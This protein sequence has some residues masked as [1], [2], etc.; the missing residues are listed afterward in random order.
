MFTNGKRVIRSVFLAL[1]RSK[2]FTLF[3]SISLAFLFLLLHIFS[4]GGIL[5]NNF[6]ENIEKRAD[7]AVFIE[8][9]VSKLRLDTFRNEL[10]GK[11][12]K[13]DIQDFWELPKEEALK[14]FEKNFPEETLFL[15][16]HNLPNP[17]STVFGI[18]PKTSTDAANLEKWILSSD[19]KGAVDQERFKKHIDARERVKRFIGATSFTGKALYIVQIFFAVISFTLIFYAVLL[20]VRSHKHEISIMR[21][22]GA[23]FSYIRFPFILEG[24]LISG[25]ALAMSIA[26]F[27]WLVNTVITWSKEALAGIDTG[28]LVSAQETIANMIIIHSMVILVLSFLAAMIAIEHALRQKVFADF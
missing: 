19:R 16:K 2:V 13:G 26:T 21:L 8:K 17:L 6:L 4:L 7:I 23:Q 15:K 3:T 22:V 14:E 5:S 24:L 27:Y 9:D 1:W 12:K 28:S 18:I 20:L 25:V 11:K 10:E